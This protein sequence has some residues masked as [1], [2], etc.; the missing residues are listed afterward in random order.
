M[1]KADYF[2]PHVGANDVNNVS[3]LV[4]FTGE[5]H[6]ENNRVRSQVEEHKEF[7]LKQIM[8]NK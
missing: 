7:L 5:D 1:R 6:Q 4:H 8:E 3:G 2:N